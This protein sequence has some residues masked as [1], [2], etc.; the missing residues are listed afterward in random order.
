MLKTFED[1]LKEV[2]VTEFPMILDDNLTDH[3]DN[4]LPGIEVDDWIKYAEEWAS[5]KEPT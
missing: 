4:W 5:I 3:F 1:Y 2:H